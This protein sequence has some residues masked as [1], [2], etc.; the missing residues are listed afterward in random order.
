MAYD[1]VVDS[2]VLDAGLKQI[3]DAIREKGGTSDNLAFPQA[4]ADAI[5]AI[6][7]GG[8]QVESGVVT[9]TSDSTSGVEIYHGLGVVP[10]AVIVINLDKHY[11][12]HPAG[13]HY[14]L[15]ADI[16]DKGYCGIG[17]SS[18]GKF[19]TYSAKTGNDS[20]G[21]YGNATTCTPL[22]ENRVSICNKLVGGARY[23]WIVFAEQPF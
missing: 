15:T 6:E 19:S 17:S 11:Y 18:N 16:K 22:T 4:M 23:F 5:A 20:T 7:A 9:L 8:A 12:T 1:K 14:L 13:S 3:A 21:P 2:S 10:N